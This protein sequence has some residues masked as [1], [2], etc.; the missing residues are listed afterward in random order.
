MEPDD[1]EIHQSAYSLV[2]HYP[3][4]DV[5]LK[6]AIA[7][8]AAAMAAAHDPGDQ[9]DIEARFTKIAQLLGSA[10]VSTARL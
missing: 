1:I 9:A 5:L 7:I 8:H 6:H 3:Y 4:R 10:M 2:G